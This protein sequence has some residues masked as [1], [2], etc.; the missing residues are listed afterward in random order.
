MKGKISVILLMS[1]FLCACATPPD[2][3]TQAYANHYE[4]LKTLHDTVQVQLHYPSKLPK[5]AMTTGFVTVQFT[6]DKG[7]LRNA[8]IVDS[9]GSD[10]LDSSIVEQIDHMEIAPPDSKHSLPPHRF[11]L[12]LKSPE[13]ASGQSPGTFFQ[14]LYQAIQKKAEVNYPREAILHGRTGKVSVGFTYFNGKISNV[15]VISSSQ[16]RSLDQAAVDVVKHVNYSSEPDSLKY[17]KLHL[18]VSIT[19]TLNGGESVLQ[20]V[21]TKICS[22]V[23]FDYLNG[24]ITDAHLLSSSGNSAFDKAAVASVAK[25]SFKPPKNKTGK[26]QTNYKI[27]VCYKGN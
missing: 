13:P 12:Q 23:G 7:K 22:E 21:A 9:T 19:Y 16:T 15:H 6:Y 25:G 1:L 14:N 3:A 2:K 20:P 26:P 11:Q 27:A 17:N 24:E 8:V 4:W 18:E 5:N 10:Q